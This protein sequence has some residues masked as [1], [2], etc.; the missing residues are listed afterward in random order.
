MGWKERPPCEI[1]GKP[2]LVFMFDTCFCGECV[3]EW[4]KKQNE[5]AI[6][7]MKEG[8]NGN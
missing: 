6:R 8:L 3:A 1:C 2:S 4:N 5:M 7:Q